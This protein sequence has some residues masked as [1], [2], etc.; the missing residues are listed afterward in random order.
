MAVFDHARYVLERSP[1]DSRAL[2][3]QAI[4]RTAMGERP[5]ARQLLEQATAS[6]PENLDAWVAHAWL[7]LLDGDLPAA[8]AKIAEA[9]QHSP[10]DEARLRDVL[11]EMQRQAEQAR[12][13]AEALA[14]GGELPAGHPPIDEASPAP[15]AVPSAPAAAAVSP[16][17][18]PETSAP[19]PP[20]EPTPVKVTLEL[21]PGAATTSGILYVMA[22]NPA[23]GPPIA[24]KRLPVSAF[25][26]TV[27]LG[28]ADSMM[29]QEIPGSFRLEARLD[30]DGDVTTKPP[31]D[32][33]AAA[34]GVSPGAVL[35]L[36]LQ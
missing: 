21:A 19:A 29:G 32:P 12:S 33:A 4:V 15:L 17:S 27:E 1:R 10:A 14:E 24:V 18:E 25:P 8:E 31:T 7:D 13:Q 16:A 30:S 35:R 36:T 28:A 9:I 20:A 22:R 34:D 26:V 23:G 5:A 3:F 2:T 6:D 11:A